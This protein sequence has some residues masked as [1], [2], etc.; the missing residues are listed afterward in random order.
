MAALF[1]SSLDASA[2]CRK[3]TISKPFT[4]KDCPI[5]AD[6]G[7]PVGGQPLVWP[8]KCVS[9]ALARAASQYVSQEAATDIAARAFDAWQSITC[10]DSGEPPSIITAEAF[11][12]TGCSRAEYSDTGANV[13]AVLFRDSVWPYPESEDALGLTN[14]AFNPVT[15]VIVDADIEVNGTEPLSISD[16]LPQSGY[17]LQ[18]ILTHE[19]GHFLGLAHSR[20]PNAVMRPTYNGGT[21]SLRIPSDDDIAGICSIYPA[22]RIAEP[23]HFT[24]HGG[25]ADECPLGVVNGGCSTSPSAATGAN[26]RISL[27]ACWGI[28]VLVLR[29]SKSRVR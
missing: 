10:P 7:C 29:R 21:E 16:E 12:P 11:G 19:V 3:T 22:N 4:C 9:Y 27:V 1:S 23:C 8:G 15:G 5:D 13:N 25:F 24:P 17:D 20:D 26:D 2:F 6:T 14:V 18:S 28:A